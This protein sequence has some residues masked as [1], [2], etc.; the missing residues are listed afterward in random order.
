MRLRIHRG[1]AEIGGNC[2][3]IEASGKS[4]LLDL[5]APLTGNL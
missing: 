5:G 3:E 1:A 4:I 2:V